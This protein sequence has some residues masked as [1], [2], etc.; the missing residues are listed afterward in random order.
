MMGTPSSSALVSFDAPGPS[1]TTSAVVF[2]ET[3]P[4]DL[5]PRALIAAS[6]CSRREALERAGDDDRAAGEGLR[7]VLDLGPLE[8]DAGRTQ[9]LEHSR[10]AS[11]ANQ[12]SSRLGD[13]GA[14]RPRPRRCSSTDA[15]RMRSRWPKCARERLCAG[16]PEVADVEPDEQVGER[17][18]PSSPRWRAAGWRPRSRPKPSSR[19]STSQSSE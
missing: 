6:I 7:H 11:S 17:A 18:L 3:L 2:L 10:W 19:R 8:V 1:P 14:R 15:S 4:G 9:P 16:R 12:C 5:P 13:R